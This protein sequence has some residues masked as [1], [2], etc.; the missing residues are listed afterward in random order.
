M[1]FPAIRDRSHLLPA[2]GKPGRHSKTRYP[3][4]RSL[5]ASLATPPRHPDSA[6]DR[7]FDGYD[8]S[9]RYAMGLETERRPFRPVIKTVIRPGGLLLP[10]MQ[11]V[12]QSL[13]PN[14]PRTRELCTSAE[15]LERLSH[16]QDALRSAIGV[17]AKWVGNRGASTVVGNVN[18]ALTTSDNNI[19]VVRQEVAELV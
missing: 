16:N 13:L 9:E 2:L 4:G 6:D 19:V 3:Q 1:T 10:Q 17:Q 14:S 5:S 15:V 18:G 8:G 11:T 12:I 7:A